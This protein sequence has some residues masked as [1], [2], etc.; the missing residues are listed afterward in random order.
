MKKLVDRFKRK[1]FVIW[2][3]VITTI[4]D[5]VVSFYVFRFNPSSGFIFYEP[6]PFVRWLIDVYGAGFTILVIVP[7]YVA[8]WLFIIHKFWFERFKWLYALTCF[9]KL[10]VVV[11]WLLFF[12][13]YLQAHNILAVLFG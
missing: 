13:F 4:I 1:E 2:F 9:V 10:S 11:G 7:L 12:V 8:V 3:L 5:I 6:N